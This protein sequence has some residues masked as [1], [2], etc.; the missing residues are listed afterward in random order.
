MDKKEIIPRI[1]E[2]IKTKYKP[3]KIIIFGSY[4]WGKPSK[5]SDV[6]LLIIK[7]TKEKHRER[8]LKVR[9]LLS[10]ENALVGLDIMVYTPEE[11]AQRIKM[12]DSFLSQILRKGDIQYG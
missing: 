11:F 12:G 7:S 6:D 9:R 10:E 8:A 3:Q 5:D 1:V 2:K 4:A